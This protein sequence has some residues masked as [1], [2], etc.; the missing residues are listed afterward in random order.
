MK[1]WTQLCLSSKPQTISSWAVVTD[2]TAIASQ[3]CLV[4]YDFQ[5]PAQT[6]WGFQDWHTLVFFGQDSPS[7]V[8]DSSKWGGS[9]ACSSGR[10]PSRRCSELGRTHTQCRRRGGGRRTLGASWVGWC[11]MRLAD[12]ANRCI[13]F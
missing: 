12:N 1:I 2:R 8:K 10:R 11:D 9:V 3:H 6:G 5:P 4:L 7:P 13:S